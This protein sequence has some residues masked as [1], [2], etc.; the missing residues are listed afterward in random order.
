M[1]FVNAAT[2]WGHIPHATAE[3]FT[4]LLA[5]FAPHLAEELWHQLGHDDT[6]AYEPWPTFDPDLLK[7]D[8]VEIAV[9]VN[10]KLR[11]KLE[12][13]ADTNADTII[14]MAKTHEK[15]IP[16]LEGKEIKMCKVI[17]GK[18]VTFAVK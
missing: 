12:V 17:P 7:E 14:A 10:G 13:A 16:F 5:P 6:L 11:A 15:V 1:E 18:L 4:L 8:S 2:K 3:A 9:Q